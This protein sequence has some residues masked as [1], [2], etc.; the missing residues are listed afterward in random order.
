MSIKAI[1]AKLF[2]KQIYNKTQTWANN[3]VTTQ[4]KVFKDLIQK[5]QK[6]KFGI[7]H[8]F[9]TIQSYEDFAK[10]VP[11]RDYEALKSYVDLVVKGEE[12]ILWPGK[13]LY[14]AKT[15][16]TTSGAKYIPL[17]AESMPY[18]IEA[19]RNAILL[20]I[21]ET[22]KAEFVDGRPS[23]HHLWLQARLAIAICRR[24]ALAGPG[25][26]DALKRSVGR[27]LTAV[28]AP[29]GRRGACAGV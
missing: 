9:D 13:P 18:H 26:L 29:A 20:Y 24:S 22:G 19:A 16:G 15:S 28:V 4:Q 6:T 12:N 2:A 11:I 14:F 10:Q 1:A 5:A 17:T 23:G 3:P 25:A 27:D 7:D 8:H 21:H